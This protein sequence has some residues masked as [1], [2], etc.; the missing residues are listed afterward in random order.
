MQNENSLQQE[1]YADMCTI[2]KLFHKTVEDVEHE[3][4]LLRSMGGVESFAFFK[5]IEN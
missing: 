1:I 5:Y 3:N 2:N 4:K